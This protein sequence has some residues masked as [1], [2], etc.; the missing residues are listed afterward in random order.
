MIRAVRQAATATRAAP[1]RTRL[2]S[3]FCTAT[4]AGGPPPIE[5][6]RSERRVKKDKAKVVEEV[7]DDARVR[8]FL[9]RG[10]ARAAD[11]G[12]YDTLLRA[13]QGMRPEDFERFLAEYVGAG[14]KLD[15]PGP[16]GRTLAQ[17]ASTHRHGAPFVQALVAAGAT[18]P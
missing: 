7:W 10:A 14:G 5:R 2:W 18:A 12:S 8:S 1:E 16:D 3:I 15:F 17:Y 4:T 9:D 6:D 13:Y 11:G